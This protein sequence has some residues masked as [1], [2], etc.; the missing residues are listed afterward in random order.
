ML[1]LSAFYL[2]HEG[3]VMYPFNGQMRALT[4][5]DT[6]LTEAQLQAVMT[7]PSH[8]SVVDSLQA[9][10]PMNE[11]EGT[12]I[13]DAYGS[14]GSGTFVGDIDWVDC[15][16]GGY[17]IVHTGEG[18]DGLRWDHPYF[19]T[20]GANSSQA[21]GEG[22]SHQLFGGV[23]S[24]AECAALCADYSGFFE[25]AGFVYKFNGGA[26]GGQQWQ[27][28]ACTLLEQVNASTATGVSDVHS[29]KI[30]SDNCSGTAEQ[31]DDGNT[32]DDD[33]CSATCEA[34]ASDVCG[35]GELDGSTSYIEV[36]QPIEGLMDLGGSFTVEALLR[37]DAATAP[38]GDNPN[39]EGFT[40][41]VFGTSCGF[42]N[43][44]ANPEGELRLDVWPSG[45]TCVSHVSLLDGELH[46][47]VAQVSEEDGRKAQLFIDGVLSCEVAKADM[48]PTAG[49]ERLFIGADTN[50]CYSSAF[51][52]DPGVTGVIP[53]F[54][55]ALHDLRVSNLARYSGDAGVGALAFEAPHAL[56]A[57]A[58]TTLR[59]HFEAG[60]NPLPE[61]GPGVP[62]DATYVNVI[63]GSAGETC[64]SADPVVAGEEEEPVVSEIGC[65]D[66]SVEGGEDLWQRDDIAFCS[67]VD[68]SLPTSAADG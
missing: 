63:S 33:G 2:P 18:G 58:N 4:F 24:E 62:V 44:M 48:H 9:H 12:T 16:S 45:A 64:D 54:D 26:D 1:R 65:D 6:A 53:E 38:V 20:D 28:K 67:T 3:G 27:D 50:G 57:D 31:C 23:P 19:D 15:P 59:L 46:H 36:L 29:G 40:S 60:A 11:G 43:L 37:L 8:G 51:S 66:G 35:L 13:S 42:L 17:E 61:S 55:G 41:R 7:D 34:E 56:E 25:C 49:G 47:V 68:D 10:Y 22:G 39:Q 14:A 52:D 30:V 5:Y 32:N 21:G